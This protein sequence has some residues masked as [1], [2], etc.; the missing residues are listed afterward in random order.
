MKGNHKSKVKPANGPLTPSPDVGHGVKGRGS[1]SSNRIKD[2]VAK[3]GLG[4]HSKNPF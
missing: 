4:K 3:V 2:R 1:Y